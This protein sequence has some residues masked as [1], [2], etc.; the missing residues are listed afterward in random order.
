MS[1]W[2]ISAVALL[3]ATLTLLPGPVEAQEATMS[4]PAGDTLA[5]GLDVTRVKVSNQ[6]F[7]IVTTVHFV[8]TRRGE[9][10]VALD[11]RGA[12][13]G[14]VLVSRYRPRGTTRN[15]VLSAAGKAPRVRCP[16]FKV[17]WRPA[18]DLAR[19]TLPSTCL[20]RGNYGAVRFAFL[21]ERNA[22]DID[23]SS[24]RS[25]FIPRG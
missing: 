5:R 8:R 21:T 10:I 25:A 4:D 7:R 19:M 14:V 13:P 23:F 1:R 18:R 2:K 9:L 17:A 20:K 16:G 22:A 3:A 12:N 11:P 6:D 15:F 24:D